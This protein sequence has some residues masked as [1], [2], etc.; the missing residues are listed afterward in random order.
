MSILIYMI[1]IEWNKLFVSFIWRFKKRF[2][3]NPR[4]TSLLWICFIGGVVICTLLLNPSSLEIAL[5]T[6]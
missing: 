6:T 4:I 5:H 1:E 3:F 2:I